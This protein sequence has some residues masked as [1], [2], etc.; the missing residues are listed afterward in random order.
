MARTDPR[1]DG[2]SRHQTLWLL[3]AAT[4]ATAPLAPQLPYWLSAAALL[5]LGWRALLW[6][7]HRPLPPRW[8]LILLAV[9]GIA[10]VFLTYRNVFGREP[11]VALL[12]LF[13]ALKLME[14][15]RRRDALAAMFLGYFLQLALFFQ[16]QSPP[17]ALLTLAA[18]VVI[19]A[20]LIVLNH[21]R[22]PW[23][24]AVRRAALMLAQAVPFMLILFVLFPRVQGPL[25]GM[26]L[27]AYAGLAGLSETMSPGSISQLSLSGAIAFRANFDAAPPPPEKLYW[28]GPVL[29]RFDGRTWHPGSTGYSFSLPYAVDAAAIEYT[30]TLEPHNKT[31]LFALELPGTVP[32]AAVASSDY[33]ILARTQ[34]R[35]RLRYAMRSHPDLRAGVGEKAE[36]LRAA[37]QLPRDA[38]PRARALARQWRAE[39]GDAQALARRALR[40]FRQQGFVYTLSPPLLGQHGIDEFLFETRRGF[41]EHYAAAFVFL[42]R[43]ADVPARVVTGYQGGEV[44]PVD[45]YLVV[46]QSDAHAWAEIWTE[47][48]GWLRVDPTAAIAPSRIERGI[49]SALPTED[50]LPLLMRVDIDWLRALRFRWDALSNAW[51][52]WVLGYNPERQREFLARLGM[53][54][55]DW[56]AMTATLTLASGLVMLVLVGWSLRRHLALDPTQRVWLRLSRKLKKFGL[57]RQDWEGPLE[58]AGRIAQARPAVAR[59]IDEIARRYAKLRYGPEPDTRRRQLKEL[60]LRIRRLRF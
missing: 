54:D 60:A 55:P 41:C 4:T 26:P 30:V 43:A 42:M 7:R 29:T 44:N 22:Q 34:V 19:T 50:A 17:V 15:S 58:Y 12:V 38:N 59:E 51:D 56:R 5:V 3:L 20:A 23:P 9:A 8:L 1:A 35:T 40:H 31:W 6:R 36:T 18:L 24:G 11:G 49:A 33:Q 48:K 53:D 13:L 47:G 2:L 28:R 37:L 10:G 32:A 39:G 14:S 46:R 16:S 45:G 27:D 52:Q 25:W 21:D 57:A